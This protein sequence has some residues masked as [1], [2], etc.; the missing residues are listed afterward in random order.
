M[1]PLAL[2]ALMIL[3]QA[4]IWADGGTVQLR[5]EIGDLV[6]TVFTAPSPLS[7]GPVDIS[8]LVQSRNGLE[9]V[10]DANVFV[11]L[12][13]NES[14]TEF[15]AHPTRDQARNKLLYAAPVMFSKPGKWEIVIA[16]ERERRE[17]RVGG[18]FEIAPTRERTALYAGY[19]A[20]PPV[21]IML[22][23][24]RERLILRRSRRSRRRPG[25]DI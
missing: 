2:P 17:V 8:L 14:G 7:V 10:L 18:V 21:M 12:H 5:R 11:L 3:A 1:K 22:F 16:V 6:I 13:E 23:A 4:T 20:F 19:I 25:K 9:P 24:I 15:Q